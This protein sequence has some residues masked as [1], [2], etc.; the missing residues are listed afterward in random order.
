MH[1]HFFARNGLLRDRLTGED[2]E[3][4]RSDFPDRSQDALRGQRAGEFDH[5]VF[6]DFLIRRDDSRVRDRCT[7]SIEIRTALFVNR[8][9][10]TDA[11]RHRAGEEREDALIAQVH[12]WLDDRVRSLR[13][14]APLAFLASHEWILDDAWLRMRFIGLCQSLLGKTGSLPHVSANNGRAFLLEHGAQSGIAATNASFHDDHE[15]T[16]VELIPDRFDEI[17]RVPLVEG[18]E[19]FPVSGAVRV[20]AHDVRIPIFIEND[21][22]GQEEWSAERLYQGFRRI[23]AQEISDG[24]RCSE[25]SYNARFS[26]GYFVKAPERSQEREME[27]LDVS[28]FV[29][30]KLEGLQGGWDGRL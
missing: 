29:R 4:G 16:T 2:R 22:R 12:E 10:V 13:D 6:G 23:R 1:V 21:L 9:R 24:F 14:R 20:H 15:R 27:S 3:V 26:E 17:F 28:V 7:D 30:R 5:V 19:I 11:F 18:N 8:D 25:V